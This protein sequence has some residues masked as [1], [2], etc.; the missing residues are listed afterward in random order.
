MN[1]CV[2]TGAEEKPD[3][4]PPPLFRLDGFTGVPRATPTEA[5]ATQC[6]DIARART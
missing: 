2:P 4:V 1:S 5:R 3:K 6:P